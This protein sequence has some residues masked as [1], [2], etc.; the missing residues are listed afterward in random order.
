MFQRHY[1]QFPGSLLL[2]IAILLGLFFLFIY[3]PVSLVTSAFAQVGLTPGQGFVIFLAILFGRAVNLPL[4]TSER[5]VRVP[6][7]PSM[8]IHVDGQTSNIGLGGETELRKQRFVLNAGGALMPVLVI[9][10]I[11]IRQLDVIQ[12]F[13]GGPGEALM[14]MGVTTLVVASACFGT[15]KP[16]T[17]AG[18]RIPLFIP[19]IA[20]VVV[21]TLLVPQPVRAIAAYTG[22]ALGAVVGGS[23]LPLLWPGARRNITAEVVTIGGSGCFGAGF[24]AGIAGILLS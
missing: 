8:H 23:L 19:A 15:A 10:T 24:I 2:A 13:P 17:G 5:L 18:M 1:V 20:T 3:A 21:S 22:G 7:G 9:M 6:V 4:W 14:W 12:A 16:D 11:Y